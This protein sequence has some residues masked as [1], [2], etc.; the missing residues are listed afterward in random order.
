[1]WIIIGISISTQQLS[2]EYKYVMSWITRQYERR[3]IDIQF[4]QEWKGHQF[5]YAKMIETILDII[6]S[7]DNKSTKFMSMSN[8]IVERANI[9]YFYKS[10]N[11]IRCPRRKPI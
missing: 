5:Y 10:R 9:Q 2:G 11:R 1:M 8:Q 3:S 6:R 4:L 7:E